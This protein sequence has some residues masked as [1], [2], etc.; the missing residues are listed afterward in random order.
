VCKDEKCVK[1]V[2]K[3]R[4]GLRRQ[5][6]TEC[7]TESIMTAFEAIVI[8]K[9]ARAIVK[10]GSSLKLNHHNEV[11]LVQICDTLCMNPEKPSVFFY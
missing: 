2:R 4:E 3:N 11:W 9:A 5:N 7:V 1:S 8:F 6:A 10:S